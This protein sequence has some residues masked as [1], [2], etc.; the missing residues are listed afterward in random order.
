MIIFDK[1]QTKQPFIVHSCC[2]AWVDPH[3]HQQ[4]MGRH[5]CWFQHF[6]FFILIVS[7]ALIQLLLVSVTFCFPF[8][9]FLIMNFISF[10]VVITVVSIFFTRH[11]GQQEIERKN[12]WVNKQAK[13]WKSNL[14]V[15]SFFFFSLYFCL[16]FFFLFPLLLL[17]SWCPFITTTALSA[18]LLRLIT[19]TMITFAQ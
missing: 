15:V 7:F 12:K 18:I 17:S 16:L 4:M 19:F 3:P 8:I 1:K 9:V 2:R 13:I 6:F 14:V 10:V 5:C 11:H